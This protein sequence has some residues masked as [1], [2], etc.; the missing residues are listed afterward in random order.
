M[1]NI[2]V[3]SIYIL[4]GIKLRCKKIKYSGICLFQELNE[5]GTDFIK[6]HKNSDGLD[7]QIK[8]FGERLIFNRL[9]ELKLIQ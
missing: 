6:Y 1:E 5:N 3:G 2:L 9:S 8:D 7:T 4:D